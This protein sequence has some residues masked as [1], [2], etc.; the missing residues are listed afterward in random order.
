MTHILSDVNITFIKP[1]HGLVAFASL[2][3]DY[4]LHLGGICVHEK[5]DG[6]L[7]LTYPTKTVGPKA[8]E[9]YHPL[10]RELSKTIENVIFAEVIRLVEKRNVGSSEKRRAKYDPQQSASVLKETV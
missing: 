2:T 8:I 10:T 1:Q 4:S 5:L 9:T 6:G 3:L 7:R